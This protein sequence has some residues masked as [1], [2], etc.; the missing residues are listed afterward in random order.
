MS[1]SQLFSNKFD[2]YKTKFTSKEKLVRK[3]LDQIYSQ[4]E[5]LKISMQKGTDND[6]SKSKDDGL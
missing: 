5:S 2:V 6:A 3:Q 4:L 1:D